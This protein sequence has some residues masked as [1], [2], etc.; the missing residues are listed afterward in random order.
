MVEITLEDDEVGAGEV[1][2]EIRGF[3]VQVPEG[4]SGAPERMLLVNPFALS[5][6]LL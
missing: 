4:V 6:V 1:K 3:A 5:L 2:E